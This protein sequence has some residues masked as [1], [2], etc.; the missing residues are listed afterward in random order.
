MA[1]RYIFE[2]LVTVSGVDVLLPAAGD[3]MPGTTISRPLELTTFLAI[4]IGGAINWRLGLG[5]NPDATYPS[6]ADGVPL[7]FNGN[8]IPTQAINGYSA[9]SVT[10]YVA[11]G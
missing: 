7:I 3:V 6:L 2:G 8:A 1:T 11:W 10:V 9:G 4:P 5:S